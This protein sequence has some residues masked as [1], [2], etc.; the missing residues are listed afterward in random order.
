LRNRA[1]S[2]SGKTAK[3]WLYFLL[4]SCNNREGVDPTK[5]SRCSFFFFS[6]FFLIE[7]QGREEVNMSVI[8]LSCIQESVRK[9]NRFGSIGTTVGLKAFQCRS[10]RLKCEEIRSG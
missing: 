6:I 8:E 7:S 10:V 2:E 3:I 4:S 1:E 5:C 9:F